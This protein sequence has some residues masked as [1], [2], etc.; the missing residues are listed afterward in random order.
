MVN[1]MFR[2]RHSSKGSYGKPHD[3]SDESGTDRPGSDL[4][5]VNIIPPP[6]QKCNSSFHAGL[7]YAKMETGDIYWLPEAIV[8]LFVL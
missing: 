7:S 1:T 3:C 2:C 5:Y 4:A 8:V 6:V